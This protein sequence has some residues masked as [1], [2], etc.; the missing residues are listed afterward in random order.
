MFADCAAMLGVEARSTCDDFQMMLFC[1]KRKEA[2]ML[3]AATIIPSSIMLWSR[4]QRGAVWKI[5]V[6]DSTTRR[7]SRRCRTTGC[8]SLLD[9]FVLYFCF[10]HFGTGKGKV[11]RLWSLNQWRIHP[12]SPK[13]APGPYD[14]WHTHYVSLCRAPVHLTSIL[15]VWNSIKGGRN[16]FIADYFQALNKKDPI[17]IRTQ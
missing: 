17:P 9:L 5:I 13:P 10:V 16:D 14:P 4:W 6:K 2:D 11:S 3:V 7:C 12:V 8:R 1:A 15:T